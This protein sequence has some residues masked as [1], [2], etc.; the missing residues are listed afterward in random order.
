MI[1][2]GTQRIVRTIK[3]HDLKVTVALMAMPR[4]R[5]ML[6]WGLFA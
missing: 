6:G 4:C 2:H 1:A 3:E 5:I